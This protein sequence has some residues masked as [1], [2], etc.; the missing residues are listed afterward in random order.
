ML[1]NIP[2]GLFAGFEGRCWG[3][4]YVSSLFVVVVI[5]GCIDDRQ[6]TRLAH[7]LVL[8]FFFVVPVNPI[9]AHD[10]TKT[11]AGGDFMAS[12]RAQNG[13]RYLADILYIF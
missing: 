3:D 6:N 8:S 13:A 4:C 7:S 2:E 5:C 12:R 10:Q 11:P 1:L 9:A